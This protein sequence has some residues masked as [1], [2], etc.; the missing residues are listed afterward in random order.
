MIAG[1]REILQN[2][3][4]RGIY[5]GVTATTLKQASNQGIRFLSYSQIMKFMKGE[6]TRPSHSWEIVLGGMA[7]GCLSV[8]GNNPGEYNF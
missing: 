2:D 4:W 7:A 5:K 1:T 6:E 8:L 3:G